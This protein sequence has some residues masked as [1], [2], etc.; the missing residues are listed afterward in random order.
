[1]DHLEYI[2]AYGLAGDFGRFRAASPL[3]LARGAPAVIKS[4][5]GLEIGRVLRPAT[6][7]H[8]AFLPNTSVGQLL[9]APGVEDE[10]RAQLV[11]LRASELLARARQLIQ[12]LELPMTLIDA[13]VLL[14]GAHATL[15][16][17]HWQRCDVRDLVSTLSSEFDLRIALLDL[18][19]ADEH[20][21]ESHGCGSCGSGGG[22][23]SCGSGGGCG[24]CGS[25][26]PEEVSA[27]FADLREKMEQRRVPLL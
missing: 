12:S 8:A 18:T 20:E 2:L 16:C 1:M 21:E 17:V 15:Q 6:P 9:R 10:A 4:A 25:A 26:Q 5:R 27:H 3:A 13:E 11:A 22:C 14:D 24:S 23:G 19:A 7:R